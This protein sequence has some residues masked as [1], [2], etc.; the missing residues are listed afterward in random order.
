MGGFRLFG[1]RLSADLA[2]MVPVGTDGETFA[3][4]LVNFVWNW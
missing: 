2:L 4:P 1:E 3:F